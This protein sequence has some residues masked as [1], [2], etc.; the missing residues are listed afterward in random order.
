MKK[1]YDSTKDTLEHIIK[2][3][4]YIDIIIEEL[5]NYKKAPLNDNLQNLTLVDLLILL[6]YGEDFNFNNKFL[7]SIYHNSK[8]YKYEQSFLTQEKLCQKY[9]EELY[10][11]KL[12]H[13][14]TKLELPE[15]LSFDKAKPLK[16]MTYG[17]EEYNKNLLELKA[18]LEHHYRYNRHHPEHF[19]NGILGMNILDMNEMICDWTATATRQANSNIF[20]GIEN[21]NKRRFNYDNKMVRILSNTVDKYFIKK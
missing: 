17:S 11:R 2:V 4:E 19:G 20:D 14:K 16:N 18:A 21:A 7:K 1:Y 6:L 12:N 5:K 15:K 10:D 9:I 13:D 8:N 3:G